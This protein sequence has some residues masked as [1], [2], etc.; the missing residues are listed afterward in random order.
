M[1]SISSEKHFFIHPTLCLRALK[2]T[3]LRGRGLCCTPAPREAATWPGPAFLCPAQ[4]ASAL[5]CPSPP[6]CPSGSQD[7]TSSAPGLPTAPILCIRQHPSHN[8]TVKD[9]HKMRNTNGSNVRVC[10][11]SPGLKR[12]LKLLSFP[13]NWEIFKHPVWGRGGPNGIIP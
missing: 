8:Q 3:P 7:V 9:L 10:S 1:F 11:L 6:L 2:S 4:G 5:G 12:Q 13:L